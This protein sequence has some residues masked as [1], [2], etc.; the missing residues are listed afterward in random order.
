[1]K[2]IAIVEENIGASKC[3]SLVRPF[4]SRS[5]Q[6]IGLTKIHTMTN[7]NTYSALA[8]N[9]WRYK[10]Y[11]VIMFYFFPIIDNMQCVLEKTIYY[12]QR[13]GKLTSTG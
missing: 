7:V 3:Q 8:G 10:F 1:M 4:Q 12:K 6:N 5:Q 13:R 2:N 9:G 11:F